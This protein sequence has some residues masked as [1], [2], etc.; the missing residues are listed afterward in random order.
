MTPTNN[1]KHVRELIRRDQDRERLRALLT[2]GA[3]S[4][5]AREADDAFFA[6]LRKRARNPR[7]E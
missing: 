4:R 2:E 3:S 6:G 5:P 1:Q 7:A